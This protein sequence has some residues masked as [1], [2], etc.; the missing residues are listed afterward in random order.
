M[1][2]FKELVLT[3][4]GIK[5]S[6]KQL[7][8]FSVL[9]QELLETNKITNLTAIRDIDSVYLKHFLDSLT[10]IKALPE[11][12]K[13]LIDIGSGA[14]FPGLPIAI[15]RPDIEVTMVESTGKK[16]A[17][18]KKMIEV[19]NLKRVHIEYVRAET[20]AKETKFKEKFDVATARAV[21]FLP[22]L[23][24]Y[25]TPLIHEDG[26]FIAMKNVNET[27]LEETKSKL[28]V[29][30]VNIKEIIPIQIPELTPRQLIVLHKTK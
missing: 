1:E 18:I 7:E 3:H 15:V 25:C 12:T 28:K 23:L 24:E 2:N 19:L 8:Q 21:A 17:F 14:G 26:L 5:L 22:K 4:I 29:F 9:A 30:K 16:A 6:A 20:L 13:T 10:L 27:E 11:K